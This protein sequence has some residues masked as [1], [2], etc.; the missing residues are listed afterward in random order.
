MKTDD[1]VLITSRVSKELAAWL[2]REGEK[3][4]RPKTKQI[5]YFLEEIRR[6]KEHNYK[7]MQD[8]A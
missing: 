8:R 2:D 4:K 1:K 5:E 6:V 3:E 7:A